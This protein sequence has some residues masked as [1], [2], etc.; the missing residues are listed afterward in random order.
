ML[1]VLSVRSVSAW[2]PQLA[3]SSS[4]AAVPSQ[5]EASFALDKSLLDG[6][7][8]S[9]TTTRERQRLSRISQPH[10]GAWVTAVPSAE[11]GDTL[12]RP[13]AFRIA[14]RLRLG[15]PVWDKGASCPCC[16]QTLDI[17]GDHAICCSTNGDLIVRHNRTRD[18]IDKIAREGHLSPIMEKRGSWEKAR[19]QAAVQAM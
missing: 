4:P 8:S 15:V 2:G 12:I 1:M 7:L 9:A 13:R 10:A 18:L 3:W 17:Y 6:L 5:Q 14:C 11:D 16:M 19:N